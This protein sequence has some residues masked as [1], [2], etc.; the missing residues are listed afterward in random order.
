MF[1]FIILKI[2]QIYTNKI[3]ILLLLAILFLLSASSSYSQSCYN[4]TIDTLI[5]GVRSSSI[6]NIVHEFT[7]DIPT[8]V[9]EHT[10]TIVTRAY[11]YPMNDTAAAYVFERFNLY[12]LNPSYFQ[13]SSTGKNVVGQKIGTKY[14]NKKYIICAHYDSYPWQARS[15]GADDNATGTCTVLEAARLLSQLSFDYTLV[16]IAMDEEERGLYGSKA[17]ADTSYAHGDSIIA[18]INIDMVAYDANYD[19]QTKIITNSNSVYYANVVNSAMKLYVPALVPSV[20]ISTSSSSDHYSFWQRGFKAVWPF[21]YDANPH[22]NSMQDT[23]TWF[24]QKYFLSMV[25]GVIASFAIL[26]K[27]YLMDFYHTPIVSSQDTSSRSAVVVI[28]SPKKIAFVNSTPKLY[29]KFNSGLFNSV[30]YYYSNLDTF[31]FMIP[32]AIPGTNV[33]YYFAAQD[34]AGNFVGTLPSGGKG[35][36]PPGSIPPPT[37]FTYS[38]MVGIAENQ[39]PVTFYLSQNYPNPFN[40][41]TRIDFSLSKASE[42]KIVV[43]DVLGKQVVELVNNKLQAGSHVAEFEANNLASGMYFYS[44]YIDGALFGTK[45]MILMK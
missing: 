6:M 5:S 11:N 44:M 26:G 1:A 31:K 29:Y 35:V 9:N 20:T 42:V 21:E 25:R 22:V 10:L 32:G 28:K 8:I 41:V 39:V 14:P 3:G 15:I 7:G 30:N 43:F 37:F 13:F 17:F 19:N 24:N 33:S 34:S 38:V 23:I 16:F 27:D 18:V 36:N 45:K 2:M 12:G 40:P 4:Y